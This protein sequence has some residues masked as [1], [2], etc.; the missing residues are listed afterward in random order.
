MLS[1][2]LH[3]AKHACITRLETV[4]TGVFLVN[5]L[6]VYQFLYFM[7]KMEHQLLQMK[8]LPMLNSYLQNMDQIFGL[9]KMQWT[10]YLKDLHIRI[11]RMERVQKKKILWTCGL[12]QVHL[13]KR[14]FVNE[15]DSVV[16]QMFI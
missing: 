1:G 5:V 6:G 11:V 16:Q 12:I 8:R 13:M 15:K 10:Y 4:K 3:G 14:F 7:Q 9:K 2:L